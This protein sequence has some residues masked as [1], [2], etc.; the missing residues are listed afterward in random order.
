MCNRMLTLPE[1]KVL[2]TRMKNIRPEIKGYP[3]IELV[4]D[5]E[6]LLKDVK[7]LERRIL[8]TLRGSLN[9]SEITI[10]LRRAEPKEMKKMPS[11]LEMFAEM[12]K[13]YP[14]IDLL[15]KRMKLELN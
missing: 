8:S 3:N 2:A 9:N 1:M 11:V 5:N 6:I 15:C 10:T 4:V 14:P 12:R 7:S 13:E